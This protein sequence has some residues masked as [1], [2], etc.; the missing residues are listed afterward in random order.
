MIAPLMNEMINTLQR[1]GLAS[2][3]QRR[4]QLAS[5]DRRS[6]VRDV[7]AGAHVLPVQRVRSPLIL[8]GIGRIHLRHLLRRIVVSLDVAVLAFFDGGVPLGP[9]ELQAVNGCQLAALVEIISAVLDQERA[10]AGELAA[11]LLLH[12]VQIVA[13]GEAVAGAHW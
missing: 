4:T 11:G 10:L 2:S 5:V 8:V 12:V 6:G 13:A 1:H 7:V 9:H 3:L